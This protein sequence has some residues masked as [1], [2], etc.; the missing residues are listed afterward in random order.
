MVGN[1]VQDFAQVTFHVLHNH[2]KV[3]EL[4][5]LVAAAIGI[6]T[7]DDVVE[8]CCKLVIIHLC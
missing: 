7:D 1:L 5:R 4:V 2:E 3:L 8:F 6:L